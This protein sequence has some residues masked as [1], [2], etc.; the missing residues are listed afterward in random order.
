[1]RAVPPRGPPHQ[2]AVEQARGRR[3]TLDHTLPRRRSDL[4]GMDA[5]RPH[6]PSDIQ[7]SAEGQ[8]S[9]GRSEGRVSDFATV[10]RRTR[11]PLSK[12]LPPGRCLEFS[13]WQPTG[14]GSPREYTD[15]SRVPNGVAPMDASQI[16]DLLTDQDL[17]VGPGYSV[18]ADATKLDR[19][20]LQYPLQRNSLWRDLG[21]GKGACVFATSLDYAHWQDLARE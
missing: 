9:D 1:A 3:G 13:I 10:P 16:E 2:R 14:R 19:R 11:A 17:F 8:A 21:P 5:R 20:T 7:G 12:Y 4:H 18:V 15:Q 6:P